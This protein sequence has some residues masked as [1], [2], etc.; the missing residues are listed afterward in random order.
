M[1]IS[2]KFPFL[3]PLKLAFRNIQARKLRT[4]LTCTGIL[5]GVAVILAISM[6]NQSTIVSL[7]NVFNEAAGKSNIIIT[8]YDENSS[9]IDGDTIYRVNN[10]PGVLYAAPSASAASELAERSNTGKVSIGLGGRSKSDAL[11]LMGIDPK[12]DREVR[13]YSIIQGRWL[14]SERYEVLLSEQFMSEN[15]LKLGNDL[16]IVTPSG[17]ERL[18]ITGV[19][20][21]SGA[22]VAN[23]GNVGFIPLQTLQEIFE[24][25]D[26]LDAIDIV[27][28]NELVE[29]QDKLD[30]LKNQIQ[31]KLGKEY[32]VQ[33]PASRSQVVPQML[34]V[35]QQGLTF[36]SAMAIFIGAFL[37]YNTFS[38][39]ILERTR[40]IGMLRAIGMVKKQIVNI[41]LTEAITLGIGGSLLGVAFGVLLGRGLIPI[42]SNVM[43]KDIRNITIPMDGLLL[44]LSVG[45]IV[46]LVSA[47]IPSI[48]AT[49]ISPI[50][51]LRSVPKAESKLWRYLW[52]IGTGLVIAA[53]LL[54]YRIPFPRSI[55]FWT[56]ICGVLLL[57]LGATL[58]IPQS[59]GR[60][61][62][63]VRPLT[64]FFYRNE[65]KLGSRNVERSPIRTTLTVACLMVGIALIIGMGATTN[66]FKNDFDK[67]IL[68]ALGGDMLIS[69]PIRLREQLGYQLASVPGVKYVTPR[70]TMDVRIAPQSIGEAGMNDKLQLNAIDP[71]TYRQINDFQFIRGQG[72]SEQIWR[73]F[74]GGNA[75]FLS[76]VT[77]DRHHL[78]QG[79]QIYLETKLGV[80]PFR[81]AAV[82]SDFT[83][84]GFIVYGSLKDAQHWFGE[85]GVSSFIVAVETGT[86]PAEVKSE[87]ERRYKKAK[88]ITVF[89]TQE[90][91][92]QVLSLVQESFGLMDTLNYIGIIISALGV[93]NTLLMNVLE[94]QRE[95]G[96]LRSMG[97]TKSQIARMVISEGVTLGLIGGAF[98]IGVGV[99]LARLMVRAMNVLGS[100]DLELILSMQSFIWGAVIAVFVVQMA[101]LYPAGR[102]ARVNIIE[103]IKHE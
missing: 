58:F 26:K 98:G 51:A 40:E 22:A 35:Y 64:T 91:K 99:V 37:I 96:G 10:I 92:T 5:L 16:S 14:E 8:P 45:I 79:D 103:A 46:T 75:L 36:F 93:I 86:N 19:L 42:M 6:T 81:V 97:M 80:Q 3:L 21:N 12:L 100:Y 49:R 76:T 56:G 17:V 55:T 72:T 69:S 61:E 52:L 68:S 15:E 89:S 27:V 73:D 24:R 95:I 70:L 47:L 102:A 66:S 7:E 77:A 28:P 43:A 31:N 11:L 74:S 54:I 44:S 50:E 20:A 59:V 25:G 29:S 33:Y 88:N 18:K 1:K 65:G 9:G 84:K 41:V 90:L 39:T 67:W 87:I 101:A 23:S 53:W 62:R 32:L 94:R 57:F 13:S 4:L 30:G 78:K 71:A 63:I 85:S 2:G 38:T 48:Q 34:F 60:F 82:V 83:P